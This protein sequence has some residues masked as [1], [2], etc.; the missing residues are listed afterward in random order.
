MKKSI[1]F[2]AV[3]LLGYYKGGYAQLQAPES[4]KYGTL[5]SYVY[6]ER[7]E[8]GLLGAWASY[9]H[10]QDLAYDQNFRVGLMQ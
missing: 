1:F 7:F 8:E 4:G 5:E 6:T 9:P 10:W 2:M 3:L